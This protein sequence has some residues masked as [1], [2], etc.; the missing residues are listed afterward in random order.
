MPNPLITAPPLNP[1]HI[2]QLSPEAQTIVTGNQRASKV[3]KP[4]FNI[5]FSPASFCPS[6]L[7]FTLRGDRCF[8]LFQGSGY[9]YI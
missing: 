8:F 1:T 9:S 6:Q 2:L 7:P 3:D 5:Q 4:K